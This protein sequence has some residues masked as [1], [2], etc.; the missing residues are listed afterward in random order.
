MLVLCPE[1][2]KHEA[3]L[4]IEIKIESEALGTRVRNF[5]DAFKTYP[6]SCWQ[7]IY[8][9]ADTFRCIIHAHK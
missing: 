4:F 1:L 9:N 2:M 7:I 5:S 6:S 8:F 3:E